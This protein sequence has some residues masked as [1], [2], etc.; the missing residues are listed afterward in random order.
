MGTPC[1]SDV[2]EAGA[3]QGFGD[4]MGGRLAIDGGVE[5]EDHLAAPSEVI[6]S[7]SR[8]ICRSSGPI[9]SSADS[10]PPSTW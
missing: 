5:R 6:R 3:F 9:S 2:T 4:V 1:A 8:G 10:V 7:T